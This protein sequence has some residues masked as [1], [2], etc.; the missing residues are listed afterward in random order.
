MSGFLAVVAHDQGHAVEPDAIARLTA[1]YEKLRA[2]SRRV[3][4]DGGYVRAVAMLAARGGVTLDEDGE[5]WV[6]AL[7]S[8]RSPER[9]LRAPLAA[10]DGQ[11]ALLRRTADRFEVVA[12]PFAIRGVYVAEREGHTYISTSALALALSL[13]SEPDREGMASFL[14][15]GL[16]FGT[17]TEWSGVRRLDPAEFLRFGPEGRERGLYWRPSI[18]SQI[19]A[20][21]FGE[22]VDYVLEASTA[23]RRTAFAGAPRFWA[24]LT[25]GFDT[26]INTLLLRRA[27]AEFDAGTRGNYADDGNAADVRIASEIARITGWDWTSTNLPADWPER[28]AAS[29]PA[30]LAWGDGQLDAVDLAAALYLDA[31]RAVR[32]TR[33]VG[34]GLGETL[35]AFAAL[36]EAWKAGRVSRVNYDNFIDMRMLNTVNT[37]IFR[38]DPTPR[39]RD[40][41]R[42]RLKAWTAPF[43]DEP[44]STQIDLC[45]YYKNTGHNGAFASAAAAFLDIEIPFASKLFLPAM[46]SMNYNHRRRNRVA[47]ALLDR[48]DAQVAALPTTHGGPGGSLHIGNA[49]RFLPFYAGLARR[50]ADKLTQKAVGRPLIRRPV[51]DG[52]RQAAVRRAVIHHLGDSRGGLRYE[53]MRSRALYRQVELDSFLQR[54][55]DPDF[56]DGRLFGRVVTVEMAFRAVGATLD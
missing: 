32:H 2:P 55:G 39:V 53:Q 43:A 19:R 22:A 56:R 3:S 14:R 6:L 27:G 11:F 45:Q 16:V 1:A 4:F 41:F 26:R 10:L 13:G 38:Q 9:L 30:A 46:M 49:H 36:Q 20:M 47:R 37:S 35:R 34:G 7:G 31:E 8:V 51:D 5:E 17:Q 44:N 23:E 29:L 54:S 33:S 25:G 28:V 18:D 40:D 42:A 48:L 50:A 24:D 21:G 12:D 52:A 15:S